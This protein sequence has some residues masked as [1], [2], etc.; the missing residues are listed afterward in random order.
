MNNKKRV[1][2]VEIGPRDGFQSVKEPIP[3]K[4]K[5]NTIENLI[6]AGCSTIQLTS[7]VS[8]KAIP[9]MWDA[10]IVVR[11]CLERFKDIKFFALVPNLI[12]AQKAIECGLDEITPVISLSESHNI[13]NVNRTHSQSLHELRMIRKEYGKVNIVL[14]VATAFGCPFEGRKHPKQLIEFLHPIYDLGI[15]GITLC[16]TIGVAAPNHIKAAIQSVQDKYTDLTLSIHIHDTRNMGMI[17]SLTAVECGINNV[18][19]ALGGLGGCPFAP[20]ASGNTATEDFVFMLDHLGYETGVNCEKLI[21]AAKELKSCVA[22]NYSGHHVHID[23]Q[24]QGEW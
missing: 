4:V 7:F 9:Q 12:G 19:T 3:T 23:K 5:L 16:D 18:Q 13:A 2:I 15:R 1:R 17:N 8:P 24:P 6:K 14:D 20:G 10:D 22:G 11:K 21:I